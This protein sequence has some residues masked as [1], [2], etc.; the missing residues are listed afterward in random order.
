[1]LQMYNFINPFIYVFKVKEEECTISDT[2]PTKA[3]KFQQELIKFLIEVS[4]RRK[5]VYCSTFLRRMLNLK[6]LGERVS[7][8]KRLKETLV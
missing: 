3:E 8:K 6:K 7:R 1:M 5:S 2:F 4:F